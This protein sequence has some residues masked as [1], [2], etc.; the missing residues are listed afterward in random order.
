MSAPTPSAGPALGPSAV[1]PRLR[2]LWASAACLLAF[3]LQLSAPPAWAGPTGL[4]APDLQ[5]HKKDKPTAEE[6][7]ANEKAAEEEAERKKRELYARVIV[8]PWLQNPTS[9]NYMDETLQR[10]VRSAIA[11]SEAMFFP[12]VDLYQ[13]GRKVPD[14]TVAPTQQ[15]AVVPDNVGLRIMQNVDRVASIP[16]DRLDPNQWGNEAAQLATLTDTLWFV[17]RV[18]LR[19]PLFLLY[20]QIGRAADASNDP[21][22]PY[23]ESIGRITVNYYFYLAALLAIQ[24]P[25]LLS[26]L[27]DQD[28]AGSVQFLL[29]Q[30]QQGIFPSFK[31][32]FALGQ[33]FD[34]ETFNKDYELLI[35]GIPASLDGN[36]QMDL[37]LGRTDVYLKRKDSGHGL[38][39]RLESDKLDEKTY[40]FLEEARKK[41]GINFV[42]Q[43]FLDKNA[44]IPEVDGDILTFLAI[45]QKLH[46]KADVFIAVPEDGNPNRT[47]IWKYDK[48]SGQ[49]RNIRNGMDTFPV[50]FALLFSSG[51]LFQGAN[52]AI[53]DNL[54]DESS[55]APRDLANRNRASIELDPATVPFNFELRGH[56]NRL[57]VNFGGE[58]GMAVGDR[59]W[60]E[61]YQTPG[62]NDE[63]DIRTVRLKGCDDLDGND[64]GTTEA[65]EKVDDVYNVR[66][67]NRYMYFGTGV[68][69]GRNAGIGFGPRLAA[70][71]GWL[72]MTHGYQTTLHFGWAVQ[73]P[74]PEASGRVRPMLDLD[75]RGGIGI[76]RDRSLQLEL[77]EVDDD[78]S[79]VK[80]VLGANL[81]IGLTF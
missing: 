1:L 64:P 25:A 70:R 78:E 67:F 51:I 63:E 37:F 13:N 5:Q 30:L 29:G 6:K 46:E 69:F 34:I 75:L 59:K 32:D 23:F 3:A 47:Y 28:V 27:T 18:E 58:F 72:N 31:G 77:A 38:A 20:A 81:G 57:M 8:L 80:P 73:P 11:R 65:C 19:E 48:E 24:E 50:R 74:I 22:P 52:Y 41:I 42:K 36:G 9:A 10:E 17:D 76:A 68:V 33:K 55:L 21:R 15:P 2:A 54:E 79:R 60:A 71:F 66:K 35:N 12:E 4:D 40:F 44:C 16:W 39:E 26:K 61:Y 49:L 7:D 14:R 45:Y 43:L 56:Y 53:D 62:K